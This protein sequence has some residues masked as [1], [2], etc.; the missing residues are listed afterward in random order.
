MPDGTPKRKYSVPPGREKV[1][2]NGQSE[3]FK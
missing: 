2:K 3:P 1:K